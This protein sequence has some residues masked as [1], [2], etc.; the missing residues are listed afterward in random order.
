M[1]HVYV[2][3]GGSSLHTLP[4]LKEVFFLTIVSVGLLPPHLADITAPP[5]SKTWPES[6][7]PDEAVAKVFPRQA[8]LLVLTNK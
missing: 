3:I 4:R 7:N 6:E 1:I 5:T 8:A 2:K